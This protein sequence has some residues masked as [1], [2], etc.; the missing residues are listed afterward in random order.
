VREQG[1]GD[2]MRMLCS[3]MEVRLGCT[4]IETQKKGTKY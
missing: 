4:L 2:P 1:N 3:L